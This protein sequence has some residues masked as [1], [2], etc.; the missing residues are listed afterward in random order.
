M[1]TLSVMPMQTTVLFADLSG[2]SKLSEAAG[3]AVALEAIAQCVE[4]LRKAAEAAGGEV[5][6]TVGDQIM[7]LFPNPDAA[8]AAAARMHAAIESLPA[9]NGAKLAVHVGFH[10]GPVI[11]RQHDVVGDTVKLASRLLEEAQRGQT[12][13]SQETADKL[14]PGF[15]AVSRD[16]AITFRGGEAKLQPCEVLLSGPLPEAAK[17]AASELRLT[18]RAQVIACSAANDSVVIGRHQGCGIVVG[19]PMASRR[20]C[21]IELRGNEYVVQDHS[22]NGTYVSVEGERGI[23]LKGEDLALRRQGTIAFGHKRFADSETIEF[24]CVVGL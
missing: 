12:V 8:A 13:T 17:S 21:T 10:A 3:E 6:K 19:D 16:Q 2:S 1:R 20:H 18:Y 14:G 24:Y 9:M 11:Q 7:A 15:R 4:R 22:T 5:I 23:L